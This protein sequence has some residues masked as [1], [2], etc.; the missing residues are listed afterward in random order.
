MGKEARVRKMDGIKR[1]YNDSWVN[2]SNVFHG[3][4][5]EKAFDCADHNK[6][7]EILQ[8]MGI[9]DHL[10]CLLRNL[11]ASQEATVRLDMEQQT[12]SKSGKEFVKAVYCHPAY[13][14]YMQRTSGEGDGTP[15]QYSRL[16]NPMDG[17]T[18]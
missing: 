6:L 13:L 9:P 17:R 3:P 5:G 10:T 15:L 2:V 1:N 7:W 8:Q 11:Y 4:R 18:W 12:G 16:E 14:T